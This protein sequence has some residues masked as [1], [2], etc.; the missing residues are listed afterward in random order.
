[1]SEEAAMSL[2]IAFVWG[3]VVLALILFATDWIA[4]ELT[5]LLIMTLLLLSRIVTPLEG[6]SGFANSAT[7]T[8]LAMFILSGGIERTGLIH[9]IAQ[10]VVAIAGASPLKQII[11]IV[12]VVGPVSAFI[13]NTAAVAILLPMTVAIARDTRVS[14]SRLLMPLSFASMLGGVMTLIGTSTNLLASGLA[15]ELIGEGFQIFTF[16]QVGFI[17]FLVGS[18][19][20]LTVGF[21]LVPARIQP[22]DLTAGVRLEEY[23]GEVRVLPESPFVGQPVTE[24]HLAK[25]MGID[26]LEVLREG[27]VLR[28]PLDRVALQPDD[29]LVV[30]ASK[31]E[32]KRISQLEGLDPVPELEEAALSLTSEDI[33]LVEVIVPPNS[34]YIG[35]SLADVNF[36]ER[37]NAQVVAISKTRAQPRRLPLFA[38][39]PRRMHRRRLDAGDILLVQVTRDALRRLREDSDLMAVEAV[40]MEAHRREKQ[41]IALAILAGVVVVA[42]LGIY[43]ILVTAVTGA[44]LMVLTGC[45][46]MGELYQSIQWNVIFLLGGLI[47]LGLAMLRT[48]AAAQ[49]GNAI[50]GLATVLP[51]LGI[52]MVLFAITALMTSVVS[53][54]ATVLVMVPVAIATASAL[55]LNSVTFI[56]AVMFAS[57]LSFI[58]PTG[59]QTNTM[60]W[61]PG[62]YKFT[63]FLVVGGPLTT[64]LTLITPLVLVV[65]FPL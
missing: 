56:L 34:R 50:A 7:I 52:L 33:S 1:M 59:Y 15:E 8:V 26:V 36:H 48:G 54:N 9:L 53:N 45:L 55:A 58:T 49:V 37:Y 60:I 27:E 18:A 3:L 29:I 23:L 65:F 46:R 17:V 25:V 38:R 12:A 61:G 13:N 39:A 24:T 28:P 35:K 16:T 31:D 57:S 10:K 4:F 44:V 43:P 14:P 21:R 63:D 6:I 11:L 30:S 2:E 47:P 51:A 20:L 64:L 22:E 62:G 5:A 32:L 40:P 19:Y 41:P 42:A